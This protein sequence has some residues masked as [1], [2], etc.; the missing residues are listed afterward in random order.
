MSIF[1]VLGGTMEKLVK[2]AN[3]K[4]FANFYLPFYLVLGSVLAIHAYAAHLTIFILQLVQISAF[5]F[6]LS[7]IF[8]RMI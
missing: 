3:R 1:V 7:K 8:L 6:Y 4:L 2:L 5:I